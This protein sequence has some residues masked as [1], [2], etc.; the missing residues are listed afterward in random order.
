M[1]DVLLIQPPIEDFYQTRVRSEPLGLMALGTELL[2][3]GVSVG[4]LDAWMEGGERRAQLPETLKE[5]AMRLPLS[6]RSPFRLWNGDYRRFG[7]TDEE[8]LDRVRKQAPKVIGFTLPMTAYAPV[9]LRIIEKIKR[10]YPQI[11]LMAGG[12]HVTAFSEDTLGRFGVDACVSGEGEGMV[13]AVAGRLMAG[14]SISQKV[15]GVPCKPSSIDPEMRSRVTRRRYRLGKRYLASLHTSRGC[16]EHCEFCSTPAFPGRTYRAR[17]VTSVVEEMVLLSKRFGI[18]AF[19]FEDDNISVNSHR[20]EALLNR[21]LE[22]F[23]E[24]RLLLTCMNGIAYFHLD[25]A[26]LPVMIRAG[27]ERLDVSLGNSLP[28]RSNLCRGSRPEDWGRLED[29]IHA[30][31]RCRLPLTVYFILGYP[32]HGFEDLL[33]L[34]QFL[35]KR[36]VFLGPS[37]FYPPPGTALYHRLVVEDRSVSPAFESCRSTAV[38]YRDREFTLDRVLSLLSLCRVLNFVKSHPIGE[39]FSVADW[40]D[41]WMAGSKTEVRGDS[42][43]PTGPKPT[44]RDLSEAARL[45]GEILAGRKWLSVPAK[46]SKDP[47]FGKPVYQETPFQSEETIEFLMKLAGVAP[48]LG[49]DGR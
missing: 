48:V 15:R 16:P 47:A 42:S 9:A 34:I 45:L 11:P 21:I 4:I 3:S 31:S 36:P 10:E 40:V 41:A 49:V 24:R 13:A 38:S 26:I 44:S 7:L 30:A 14:G 28:H 2:R 1:P 18:S 23:G 29:L 19:D 20:F 35:A 46:V 33:K 27:F 22:T 8:I 37:V 12:H 25:P 39:V 43:R 32:G 6:D 17:S 5:T